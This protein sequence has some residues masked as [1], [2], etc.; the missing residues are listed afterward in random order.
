M[1]LDEL[2]SKQCLDLLL[3]PNAG[4]P[5]LC[6]LHTNSTHERLVKSCTLPMLAGD[7]T[8]SGLSVVS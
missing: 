1:I 6:T 5:G 7:A 2:R 8:R 4:L 3:P